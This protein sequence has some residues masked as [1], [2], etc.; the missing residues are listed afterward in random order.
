MQNPNPRQ[1]EHAEHLSIRSMKQVPINTYFM[2][3]YVLLNF[4]HKNYVTIILKRLY[5]A[6]EPQACGSYSPYKIRPGLWRHF[7]GFK[8][9]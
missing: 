4:E 6:H 5:R 2:K 7:Y 3:T 1:S 8:I 9:V